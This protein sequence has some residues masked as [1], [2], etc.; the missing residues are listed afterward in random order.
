MGLADCL[1]CLLILKLTLHDLA[2]AR[3]GRRLNELN[4]ARRFVL[5]HVFASPRDDVVLGHGFPC[6]ALRTTIAF[7]VSSRCASRVAITQTILNGG[8]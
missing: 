4:N 5:R 1:G 2:C 7:T 6:F 8:W 3:L